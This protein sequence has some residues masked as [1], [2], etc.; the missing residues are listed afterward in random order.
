MDVV[1]GDELDVVQGILT[2]QGTCRFCRSIVALFE[3]KMAEA[4]LSE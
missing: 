3:M 4:F 2:R 1:E